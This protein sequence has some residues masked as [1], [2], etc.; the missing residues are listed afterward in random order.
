MTRYAFLTAAFAALAPSL[1]AAQAPVTLKFAFPAPVQSGVNTYGVAPWSEEVKAAAAGTIDIKLFPIGTIATVANV[2]D[3]TLAGVADI[4]FGIFGPL[5]GIFSQVMVAAL[6]F[7]TKNTIE[8]SKALW[9]LYD[10]GL[11][12]DEFSKVKVLSLFAFP[13]AGLHTNKPIRTMADLDGSKI[14]TSDRVMAQLMTALGASAV[15]MGPPDYYQAM[16]RGL[17][18]GIAVGWSA[19]TTFKLQEVSNHHLD[20]DAGLFAAFIFMNKDSYARLPAKGREAIDRHSGAPFFER[21]GRVTDRMNTEG[22]DRVK[23]L[24]GHT[25]TELADAEAA[26]WKEKAKPIVDQWVRETSNGAA[27]LAAFREEIEKIRAGR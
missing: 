22:R 11:I 5:A 13:S 12:D 25:V 10:K 14:A 1:A 26:R 4:S 3:R 21:M 15:T 16:Q 20:T 27:I 18:D 17:A 8:A 19:V 23:A 6:P 7:E 9:A 2:Y 24:P